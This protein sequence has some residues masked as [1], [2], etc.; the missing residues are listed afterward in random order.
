MI[1]PSFLWSWGSLLFDLDD[2][3]ASA[4]VLDQSMRGP[5]LV[6]DVADG[7]IPLSRADEYGQVAVLGDL[8]LQHPNELL[9]GH[10]RSLSSL[11]AKDCENSGCGL[12]LGV[13]LRT[14]GHGPFDG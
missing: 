6:L 3:G 12:L 8:L 2:D 13:L 1:H 7:A 4:R 11:R 10:H 9:R 14:G 5:A